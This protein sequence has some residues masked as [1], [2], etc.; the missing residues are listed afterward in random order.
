VAALGALAIVVTPALTGHA[1]TTQPVGLARTVDV[2]H[3][4]AAS[5]WLGALL[6]LLFT[7]LPLVRGTRAMSAIG[8]GPLVASLVQSFHPVALT[9]SAIVVASGF[10]AAWLR[11]P[12]VPA[13]W[14]STYGRLLLLKLVFVALVVILG[15]LN[16][17]R[18]LPSLG[19]EIAARRITRTA[20][21]ELTL[22]AVVLAVTAVLVSTPTP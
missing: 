21:A 7:A 14:E 12:T 3:V 9:C 18:M 2:L 10:V 11:L 20:G 6:S 22:A 4:T 1:S 19:D 8:S 17:R 16:W 13:L 15:A 5:A